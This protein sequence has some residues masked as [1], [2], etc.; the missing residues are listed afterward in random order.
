[1]DIN[2]RPCFDCES[3]FFVKI[4]KPKS[5]DFNKDG[6]IPLYCNEC[7]LCSD[8]D[9]IV[10]PHI[11]SSALGNRFIERVLEEICTKKLGQDYIFKKELFKLLKNESFFD[12]YDLADCIVAHCQGRGYLIAKDYVLTEIYSELDYSCFV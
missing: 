12:V 6:W 8:S 2:L 5:Y 11:Y 4:E 7:G 9:K 10:I 1:M 3:G